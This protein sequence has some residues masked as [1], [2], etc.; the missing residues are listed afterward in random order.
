MNKTGEVRGSSV[1]AVG[2]Q[3]RCTTANA[4]TTLVTGARMNG[5]SRRGFR[6]RGSPN[7]RIS[8]TFKSATG[9]LARAST[10]SGSLRENI[11]MATTSDIVA[12]DPPMKTKAP[13]RVP[14]N[15][16]MPS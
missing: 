2:S 15:A 1:A 11:R 8:F 3:P 10:R 9:R 4:M 6:I 5:T 12:P 16:Y 7:S 14:F 13:S